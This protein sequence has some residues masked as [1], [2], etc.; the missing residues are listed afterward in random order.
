[1]TFTV[2]APTLLFFFGGGE[3]HSVQHFEKERSEKNE[4][5]RELKEFFLQIFSWEGYYVSCQKRL[6]KIKYAF[7]GSVL[8][9]DLGYSPGSTY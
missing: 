1:M 7:K 5:L 8:D 9:V 2:S 3:Q 6:C 4:C